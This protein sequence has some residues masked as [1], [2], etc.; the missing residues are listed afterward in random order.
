MLDDLIDLIRFL[1]WLLFLM[2]CLMALPF[3]ICHVA[4]N[5]DAPQYPHSG[6]TPDCPTWEAP[7]NEAENTLPPTYSLAAGDEF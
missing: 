7:A 4:D 2:F 6:F 5:W 3:V 1:L